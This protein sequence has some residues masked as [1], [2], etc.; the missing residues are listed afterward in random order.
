MP[1]A[2]CEG[3]A[4]IE[5]WSSFIVG[6]SE[7][8]RVHRA[9]RKAHGLARLH[10]CIQC[11]QPAAMWAWQHGSD[12]ALI[13]SYEPMCAACH[14]SYDFTDD[15]REAISTAQMGN[16]YGRGHAGRTVS[17]EWRAKIAATLT[18][19]SPSAETR[20][21]LSAIRK[22][23][24]NPHSIGNAHNRG[25]GNGMSKLTEADVLEIRKLVHVGHTCK[26]VGEMFGLH[27]ASVAQIVRRDRWRHI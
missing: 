3:V 4:G 26:E 13:T 23:K 2:V 18:G 5:P 10:S 24:P 15:W 16:T 22:G 7:Y 1:T 9:V 20:A 19:H 11:E 12:P 8:Q 27:A 17:P 21:K 25:S 14:I 6:S